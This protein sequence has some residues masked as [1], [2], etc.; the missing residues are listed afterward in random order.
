MFRTVKYGLYAA[1]L[2]GLVSGTVAW[3]HVDK[4]VTLVVDGQPAS[5][6]TTAA[7]V[8]AVIADAGYHDGPHDILAPAASASIADGG[9]IVFARG[10]LLRLNVDGVQRDVWT[11]APTV[12]AALA[13]LGY[14]TADFTSVSRDRRLPLSPTDISVRT[15]KLVTVVAGGKSTRVTTTDPTVA[16]VLTDLGITVGAND[17]LTPSA[18][19][20]IRDD[21]KIVVQ[22]VVKRT[23]TDSV[24]I[25]F[26]T[27][28]RHDSNLP[29][30][31][32][33]VLRAGQA[34]LAQVTW[35]LV[36]VDGK[37]AGRTKVRTVT[38]RAPVTKVISVGTK[39]A[40]VVAAAPAPASAAPAP[41]PGS[42]QAIAQQ[43]VA[44]RGWG[45][46]QFDCLVQIWDRESGWNV[47]AANPSGAYGIP[48]AL[49]GS[50][51]GSAGPD[52]QDNATTQI[53][54]GL[55]YISGRYGTPCGAWSF[56]QSNGW[57]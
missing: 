32:T 6:H 15:P 45:S 36:Y 30:G 28:T 34:G 23:V 35:A 4:T 50:K 16:A 57:Y 21:M 17:R 56:W 25:P 33:Q 8:G 24:P 14:S 52:W 54:W 39:Q 7:T 38:V 2:A 12:S 27:T 5:L 51:M 46:D 10:R 18:A 9:R 42:A 41:S 19:S 20:A 22:Q 37:L 1:V 47:H 40:P 31:Q 44:A 49:P 11:T 29:A 43:L 48:Q 13:Q 55:G 26:A 53:T 3:T